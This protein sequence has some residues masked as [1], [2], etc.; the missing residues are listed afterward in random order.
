MWGH[1]TSW[2]ASGSVSHSNNKAS[3]R[4]PVLKAHFCHLL[5]PPLQSSGYLDFIAC[6]AWGPLDFLLSYSRMVFL[7]VFTSPT[8]SFPWYLTFQKPSMVFPSQQ[9]FCF[10]VPWHHISSYCIVPS[11][12]DISFLSFHSFPPFK[13]WFHETEAYSGLFIKKKGIWD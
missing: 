13:C 6:L 1:L 11:W 4:L 5:S 12:S 3:C 2:W 9:P 7:L 8:L 10:C